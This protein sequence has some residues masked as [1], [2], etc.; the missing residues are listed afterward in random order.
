MK[1][2][3]RFIFS[4]QGLLNDVVGWRLT[5]EFYTHE[6]NYTYIYNP[7]EIKYE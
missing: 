3:C 1:D 5:D 7:N 2:G 6:E 4:A